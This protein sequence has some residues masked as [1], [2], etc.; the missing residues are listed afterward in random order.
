MIMRTKPTKDDPYHTFKCDL[1]GQVA[2]RKSSESE[3]LQQARE[4]A[5]LRGWQWRHPGWGLRCN[6]CHLV[7][8]END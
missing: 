3:A 4:T 7:S 8:S 2:G 6:N 1:C 5:R